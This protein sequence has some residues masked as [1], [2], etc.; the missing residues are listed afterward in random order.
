MK[1]LKKD[2][3]ER[4]TE[5]Q[6][7]N[8]PWV[9]GEAASRNHLPEAHAKIKEFNAKRRLKVTID[10]PCLVTMDTLHLFFLCTCTFILKTIFNL[11]ICDALGNFLSC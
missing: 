2:P 4:L 3:K 9:T 10:N 1:M 8:H 11:H 5:Y 6:A 7:L